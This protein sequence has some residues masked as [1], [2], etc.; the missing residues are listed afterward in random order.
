DVDQ[1]VNRR[2]PEKGDGGEQVK[3]R[4]KTAPGRAGYWLTDV[5]WKDPVRGNCLREKLMAELLGKRYGQFLAPLRRQKYAILGRRKPFFYRAPNPKFGAARSTVN[6]YSVSDFLAVAEA[7]KEAQK[8]LPTKAP[9]GWRD[10]D[11]MA[12]FLVL[13]RA[14]RILRHA[15]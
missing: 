9:D 1:I 14:D 15:L 3:E 13:E 7:I 4:R 10:T 5:V 12:E 8:D 6:V 2:V 11:G